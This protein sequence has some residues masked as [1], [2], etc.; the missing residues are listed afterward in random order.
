MINI[1]RSAIAEDLNLKEEDV[2]CDSCSASREDPGGNRVYCLVWQLA[3]GSE[4][5]CNLFVKK[6]EE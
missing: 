5:F 4:A 1:E 2:K 3:V 6:H